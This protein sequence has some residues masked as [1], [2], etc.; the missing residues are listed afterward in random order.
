MRNPSWKGADQSSNS[1]VI[2]YQTSKE[3]APATSEMMGELTVD[4]AI[5]GGGVMGL[6]TAIGLAKS[7]TKV[8]VLEAGELGD[9]AS[10]RNGGLII[11]LMRLSPKEIHNRL[12][13]HGEALVKAVISS[14]DTVFNLVDK[15][16]IACDP[17]RAGFLQSVHASS[18]VAST[19]SS[20]EAWNACGS[21]AVFIDRAETQR[22]L[23]SESYYGALFDPD[24]GCVNPLAYVRGLGRVAIN[25]GATVH[26][27]SPVISATSIT[28]GK[29]QLTTP[30]GKVNAKYVVQ[31]VSAQQPGIPADHARAAA[32]SLIPI[33]LHGLASRPVDPVIR[34]QILGRGEVTT[35]TRNYV[36]SIG[37][38][39][40]GRI[41]TSGFRIFGGNPGTQQMVHFVAKRLS[42][43]FPQLKGIEFEYIWHGIAA[44]NR[45]WLPR[46]YH[47]EK[48]WYALTACN[49]RGMAL[50]TTV[51][52]AFAKS[53]LTEN[54]DDLPIPVVAPKPVLMGPLLGSLMSRLLIPA[55]ALQ[56]HLRA[57]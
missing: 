37:Y 35:D 21:R 6:A 42:R 48:G 10:G 57:K 24:A 27:Q 1:S 29:W 16:A 3:S 32:R 55:G 11:P 31:C 19:E 40:E 17:V 53:L 43:V 45:D 39:V 23:G 47:A 8:T 9:G 54:M 50:S 20:A 7:G 25:L 15:Y 30:N 49:G 18:L 14:A 5:I 52:L 2:W 13:T 46:L 26:T 41:V 34:Q 4:V 22:I 56:D 44:L 33:T 51:G 12:G 28:G 38:D 36:L